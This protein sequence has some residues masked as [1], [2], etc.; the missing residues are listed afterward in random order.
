MRI[1]VAGRAGAARSAPAAA[2]A[3]AYRQRAGNTI[4]VA[5]TH[6]ALE[7]LLLAG[8]QPASGEKRNQLR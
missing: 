2:A 8:R 7:N 3:A 4:L 6:F 1:L 5:V